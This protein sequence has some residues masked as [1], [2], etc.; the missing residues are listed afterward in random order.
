MRAILTGGGTG[1]HIY[2]ALAIARGLQ[3]HFPRTEILYVGTNRGLEAD[4]V[5]KAHFP[6]QAITVSGLARKISL[7]NLQVLW[8]AWQGYREA[9]RIIKKFQPDIVIGTGG[10]VCGPVVMAAARLGIPTLIHEQNAL[11]GITNRIL[12]RFVDLVAV[13]FEDSRRYFSGKARVKLTGLPIRPEILQARR[14]EALGS[15]NLSREKLT[16]LVFGGSRGARKINQAMIEV[17]KR[18][19]NHPQ[20]QVLHA[21]GQAGYREFLQEL[22]SQSIVLDK[23]VNIIV[24]PYLYNMHEALAAADLVVSRAGA[25]TLAE[26][27]ALGLPAILIPYPYAAENHQE[28]NARAL[29]DRGAAVLIKDAEL[30]G[31]RLVESIDAV[32]NRPDKRQ[33]MARASQNLGRPEALRDIIKCVEEILPRP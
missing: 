15:L 6:F 23:Y 32:I 16:L 24:K 33:D 28:Y 22:S 25:A 26:L 30:T 20:V 4:I 19:G 31:R 27:T 10:Y 2:P 29:A 1:G 12:S 14:S 9:G 5:P 13:T 8:Q 11:P 7:A 18:Y 17:I 21:T 3:Q